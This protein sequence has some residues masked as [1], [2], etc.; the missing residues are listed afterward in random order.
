[1]SDTPFQVKDIFI[2]LGVATVSLLLTGLLTGRLSGFNASEMVCL[3][4]LA[5]PI[6][7]IVLSYKLLEK[8]RANTSPKE[9]VQKLGLDDD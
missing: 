5:I 3:G 6:I 8:R 7:V 9:T 1:M 2:A 4:A